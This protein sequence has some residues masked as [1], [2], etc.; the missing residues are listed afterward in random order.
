[1]SAR[2]IPITRPGG[3]LSVEVQDKGEKI[4]GSRVSV[5]SVRAFEL[6]AIGR[7]PKDLPLIASRICGRHGSSLSVCAAIALESALGMEITENARVL[8]NILLGLDIMHS[9]IRSFFLQMLPDYLDLS[10]ISGYSGKDPSLVELK[11]QLENL[12]SASDEAPFSVQKGENKITD[13]ATVLILMKHYSEALDILN[14]ISQA[15]AMVGGKAPGPS[16]I[17]TGG[18]TIKVTLDLVNKLIFTT[19]KLIKW[20]NNTFLSDILAIAPSLMPFGKVG[21]SDNFISFGGMAL[22]RLGD[23]RFFDRGIIADGD[24]TT[25]LN[26]ERNEINESVENSWFQWEGKKR[27]P[28]DGRTRFEADKLK[29]YS[30]TKSLTYRDKM[31]ESGPLARMLIKQDPTL[32]KLSQDLKIRPSA[33]TRIASHA[34]ETKLIAESLPDWII[35]LKPGEQTFKNKS[36][37]PFA[38]GISLLETA[39][40]ATGMWIRIEKSLISHF[41]FISGSTWNLSPREKDQAGPVE[42]SLVGLDP[43]EDL[44]ILRVVRSFSPCSACSAH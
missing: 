23:K 12:V 20:V 25:I 3:H 38:E 35:E 29:G 9:H 21:L 13:S 36:T 6:I 40:G 28:V 15:M 16:S 42:R 43:K 11:K 2:T 30:F 32:L 39:D 18:M 37:P 17:V 8:R 41:Q 5:N 22:D 7:D 31:M 44:D 1:M 26:M 27:H 33:L 14:Q 4:T 34:I 10:V 24:L 19:R